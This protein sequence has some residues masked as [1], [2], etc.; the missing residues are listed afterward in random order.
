[1]R[2]LWLI[3][4]LMVGCTHYI[5]YGNGIYE[6]TRST[7]DPVAWGVSHSDSV[8]E[9]CEGR[10]VEGYHYEKLEFSNC[11]VTE[12]HHGTAPGYGTAIANA[13]ANFAT[14]GLLGW[15]WGGGGGGA[16][17]SSSAVQSQSVTVPAA[18]GH[19]GGHH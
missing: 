18:S 3:P 5:D 19:H 13:F 1:M 14:F 16:T 12:R 2:L 15:I 9:V 11:I 7:Q 17:S 10:Q 4:L 8:K 6:R